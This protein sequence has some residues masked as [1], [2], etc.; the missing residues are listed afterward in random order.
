LPELNID[1]IGLIMANLSI[2]FKGEAFY[3]DEILVTIFVGEIT[4]VSFELFYELT[5]IRKERTTLI[6]LAKTDMVC[7]NYE[8]KKVVSVSQGLN[9]ILK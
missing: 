2:E 3:G 7:Y 5:T 8:T 4:R 1:G 9:N 6:G